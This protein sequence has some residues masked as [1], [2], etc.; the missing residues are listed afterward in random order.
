MERKSPRLLPGCLIRSMFKSK[1]FDYRELNGN[2]NFIFAIRNYTTGAEQKLQFRLRKAR[3][4]LALLNASY[5]V[6]FVSHGHLDTPNSNVK[7]ALI[8]KS[9]K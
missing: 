5:T 6:D 3:L 2:P 1:Q 4:G 8:A 9:Q 7:V